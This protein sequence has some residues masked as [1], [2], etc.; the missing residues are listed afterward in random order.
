M[1]SEDIREDDAEVLIGLLRHSSWVGRVEPLVRNPG[2]WVIE[3]RTKD[4]MAEKV[5]EL[6][7]QL[8]GL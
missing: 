4:K 8:R 1:F 7:R 6:Y 3:Q 5:W 2:D